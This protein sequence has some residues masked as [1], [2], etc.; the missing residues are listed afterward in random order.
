MSDVLVVRVDLVADV[1]DTV[2]LLQVLEDVVPGVLLTE[3]EPAWKEKQRLED[4]SV[5]IEPEI[6]STLDQTKG[7]GY[8]SWHG[9]LPV[10]TVYFLPRYYGLHDINVAVPPPYPASF[11]LREH[12]SRRITFVR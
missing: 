7:V 2:N 9:R 6:D 10:V 4:D 5:E 12:I 3:Q 8:R 1:Q 11:G